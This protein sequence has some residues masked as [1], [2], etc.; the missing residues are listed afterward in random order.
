MKTTL[1][2]L[3][4]ASLVN[5][6]YAQIEIR[7]ERSCGRW[8]ETRPS[9][10]DRNNGE[11]VVATEGWLVGFMAGLAMGTGRDALRGT[12]LPS[13]AAWVDNYCKANPLDG[14]SNAGEALFFELAKRRGV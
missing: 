8:L 6:V 2:L 11:A 12:D 14:L 5:P 7:G 3:L 9:G 13:M 1:Q 4:L 10:V